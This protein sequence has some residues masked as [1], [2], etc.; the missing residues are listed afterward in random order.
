MPHEA[1]P[2]GRPRATESAARRRHMLRLVAEGAGFHRAADMAR[3][4]PESF[5]RMLDE[6]EFAQ[7]IAALLVEHDME[8]RAA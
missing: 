7:V 2:R 5:L 6:P 4:K 8:Q 3:V 1:P